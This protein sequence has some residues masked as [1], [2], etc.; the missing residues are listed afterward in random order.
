MSKGADTKR[1]KP[2]LVGINHIALEV[3]DVEQALAFYGQIF[4]FTL[5]GRGKGH[6]PCARN[7]R[8]SSYRSRKSSSPVCSP[9]STPI[10]LR[11]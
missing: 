4:E 10:E 1:G 2:R 11:P 3:G 8:T 7:G 5:R 6:G 9:K